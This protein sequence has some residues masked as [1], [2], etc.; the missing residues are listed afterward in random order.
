VVL[1]SLLQTALPVQIGRQIEMSFGKWWQQIDRPRLDT[2]PLAIPLNNQVQSE[3]VVLGPI[4]VNNCDSLS[5]HLDLEWKFQLVLDYVQQTTV[6]LILI[7]S[8]DG[9]VLQR[10]VH[11]RLV[12]SVGPQMRSCLLARLCHVKLHSIQEI[13]LRPEYWR[14]SMIQEVMPTLAKFT[15]NA[16]RNQPIRSP[17]QPGT[18]SLRRHVPQIVSSQAIGPA[19]HVIVTSRGR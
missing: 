16:F 6:P 12:E 3:F 17:K 9:G 18:W 1:V 2:M 15:K 4:H 7:V 8:I 11:I 10:F 19:N 13:R 14:W 5:E